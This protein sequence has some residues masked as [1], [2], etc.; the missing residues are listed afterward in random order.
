MGESLNEHGYLVDIVDVERQLEE[1]IGRYRSK[2]L[3]DLPEFK[4]L[5]PSIEHFSRILC[6][7]LNQKVQA[8]NLSNV[9]VTLWENNIAWTSYDYER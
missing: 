2:M 1:T 3:N 6:E 7:T 8:S 9:K 4:G 5:N